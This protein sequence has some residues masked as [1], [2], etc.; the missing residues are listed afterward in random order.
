[1]AFPQPA[2]KQAPSAEETL[3][4]EEK[5]TRKFTAG[6]SKKSPMRFYL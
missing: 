6:V 3:F 4:I 5:I 1:V 2:L